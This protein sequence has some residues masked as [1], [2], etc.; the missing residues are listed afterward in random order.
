M[1]SV[2]ADGERSPYLKAGALRAAARHLTISVI[3][4]PT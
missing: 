4:T 1:K 2:A 3:L